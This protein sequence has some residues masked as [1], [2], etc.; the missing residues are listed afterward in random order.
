MIQA[1]HLRFYEWF[2]AMYSRLAI[3]GEFASINRDIAA[4]NLEKPLL[5]LANHHSWWDGFWVLYLNRLLWQ[6]RFHVM[7]LYDQLRKHMTFRYVGAYSVKKGAKSVLESLKYTS[8]LLQKQGNMVLLFP[9]GEIQSQHSEYIHF[10]KGVRKTIAE[11]SD[12]EILMLVF[13]TDYFSNK[14]NNLWVY[15]ERL[16][17]SDDPEAAFNRF[18][19]Q[20]KQRQ[21]L[22]NG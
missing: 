21:Q 19:N 18:Y 3:R 1:R 10:Q 20:C 15:G 4:I 17:K 8:E 7:M 2:Y 22:W 14:K 11:I 5:I 16:E 12:V 9:Q 13:F 6:K